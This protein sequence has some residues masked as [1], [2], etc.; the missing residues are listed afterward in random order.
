M[1]FE[2]SVGGCGSEEW[3][4]YDIVWGVCCWPMG[5]EYQLSLHSIASSSTLVWTRSRQ[6]GD[7]YK[8]CLHVICCDPPPSLLL[9]STVNLCHTRP[10]SIIDL[11][12]RNMSQDV[13]ISPLATGN[14]L[15]CFAGIF[16]GPRQNTGRKLRRPEG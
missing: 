5:V 6:C 8:Y 14:T 2:C 4:A 11:S 7:R 3:Q 1:M 15:F 9:T 12:K 13:K 10:Y 16:S